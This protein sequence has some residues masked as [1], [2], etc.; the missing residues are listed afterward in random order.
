M[1]PAVVGNYTPHST[2]ME[3]LDQRECA[4]WEQAVRGHEAWSEHTCKLPDLH[5]GDMC[6][7]QNQMGN[8]PKR[9][10]KM[11]KVVEVLQNDQ[12]WLKMDGTGRVT[13]WNRRFLRKYTPLLT[14]DP[15]PHDT[16]T[17]AMPQSPPPPA[18]PCPP[19]TPV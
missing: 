7:V 14:P 11:G 2:W 19:T 16:P 4:L 18:V 8:Y 9:F 10:D 12:Y 6:F 17:L 13:L 5:V 1:I 3:M 15:T